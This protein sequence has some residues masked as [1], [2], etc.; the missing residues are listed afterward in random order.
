VKIVTVKKSRRF[1][2]ALR[3]SS[4]L[5]M[6]DNGA[7]NAVYRRLNSKQRFGSAKELGDLTILERERRF[8]GSITKKGALQWSRTTHAPKK[9]PHGLI[10][11]GALISR[12]FR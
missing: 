10:N 9:L 8:G 4:H 6:G 5:Y 12:K 1:Q 11:A 7:L 3:I 2:S